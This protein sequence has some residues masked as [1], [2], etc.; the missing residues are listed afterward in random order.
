MAKQPKTYTAPH[1][2]YT[3]GVY[4]KPGQPFTTA[5]DAGE[6][7]ESIDGGEKAAIEA[8]DKSVH[9]DVNLDDMDLPALR[10]FAATKKVASMGLGKKDLITAIKAADEPAL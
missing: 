6:K 5:E 7:W 1:P 8:S 2:V 9:N 10:A 4:Y 3:G